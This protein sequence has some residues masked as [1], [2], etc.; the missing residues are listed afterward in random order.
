LR[1]TLFKSPSRMSASRSVGR[2]SIPRIPCVFA[3][4]TAQH[5]D[6]LSKGQVWRLQHCFA[7][8]SRFNSSLVS[9][10]GL[11]A[12]SAYCCSDGL[13]ILSVVGMIFGKD[14][15]QLLRGGIPPI[16][17]SL[18]VTLP[19]RRRRVIY[20]VVDVE[21]VVRWF[22]GFMYFHGDHLV[23]GTAHAKN[24]LCRSKWRYA[25]HPTSKSLVNHSC[26]NSLSPTTQS[27]ANRDFPAF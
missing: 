7:R 8:L 15:D 5:A 16:P 22:R 11:S 4:L 19:S 17:R 23:A 26:R 13:C 3:F 12:P 14:R 24:L 25:P 1:W 20:A 2:T 10:R 27:R 9:F 21:A 18:R 6:C